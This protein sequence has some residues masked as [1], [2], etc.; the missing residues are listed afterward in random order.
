M[1]VLEWQ[2]HVPIV[3]RYIRFIMH[4]EEFPES[5]FDFPPVLCIMLQ[6][7]GQ[8]KNLVKLG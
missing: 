2:A 5:H 1:A 3:M 7:Q 6:K 4:D 8:L